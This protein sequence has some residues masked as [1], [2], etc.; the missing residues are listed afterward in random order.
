MDS[1]TNFGRI[2]RA[3]AIYWH[4]GKMPQDPAI[5]E[6]LSTA[7]DA[8]VSSTDEQIFLV[9]QCGKKFAINGELAK[10]SSEYFT[11]ALDAGMTESGKSKP[12]NLNF[13]L[14]DCFHVTSYFFDWSISF[15]FFTG[16]C[17]AHFDSFTQ[18]TSCTNM[19]AIYVDGL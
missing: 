4:I 18:S 2:C 10:A 1:G 12:P 6:S 9:S 5:I 14:I 3:R 11:G 7:L 15:I 17:N 8:G 19:C 16:D 13:V